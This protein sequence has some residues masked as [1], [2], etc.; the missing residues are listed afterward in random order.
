MGLDDTVDALRIGFALWIGAGVSVHL[1]HHGGSPVPTWNALV[2]DIERDAGLVPPTDAAFPDRL[3]RALRKLGRARF[4]AQLRTRVLEPAAS[5]VVGAARTALDGGT[6]IP[7]VARDL[8][9]LGQLANPIVNFNIESL[10]SEL[11]ARPAGPVRISP[12]TPHAFEARSKQPLVEVFTRTVYHPHGVLDLTGSC[13]MSRRDYAA[14]K[15]TL[16]L[17]LA[18][19]QAFG[20]RLAIVGMSL[21]DEYLRSQLALFRHQIQEITWFVDGPPRPELA[22]WAWTNDVQVVDVGGWPAFWAAVRSKVPAP[23]D[24]S[25]FR[26]WEAVVGDAASHLNPG[27]S[28]TRM[29]YELLKREGAGPDELALWNERIVNTGLAFV[30]S[31]LDKLGT[32]VAPTAAQEVHMR[33]LGHWSKFTP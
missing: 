3:E 28:H 26:A 13:V 14:L 21:D 31:E 25:L 1:G 7:E 8:A 10:T 23:P 17:Q 29:T 11:V 22:R 2:A 33:L 19:H 4:Q 9:A 27:M 18:V 12:F 24:P 16:A 32:K 6:I 20:A 15:D 5:A 30:P